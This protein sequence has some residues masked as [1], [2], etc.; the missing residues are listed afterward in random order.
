MDIPRAIQF[1]RPDAI[2]SLNGESYIDLQWHSP[3]N[4]P[5]LAELE[6]L[7]HFMLM[8]PPRQLELKLDL[9]PT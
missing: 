5:T 2:W 3:G 1:L 9:I 6:A 4:A 7:K 8:S